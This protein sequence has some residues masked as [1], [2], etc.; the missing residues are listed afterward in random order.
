M[1]KVIFRLL[2]GL[3]VL[4][5]ALGQSVAGPIC[6]ETVALLVPQL[7]YRKPIAA[8]ARVE[9]KRCSE[10]EVLKIAAWSDGATE[11]ALVIDTTDFTIVQTYM[12]GVVFLVETTGGPRNRVYV[13]R[14]EQGKPRL[15]IERV[16]RG[17]TTI[18]D[19]GDRIVITVPNTATGR[20]ETFTF[21]TTQ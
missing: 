2:L 1:S 21:Q 18:M 11:P 4:K 5:C 17:R 20:A 13:I 12:R 7:V 19:I 14:Y 9:V 3:N 10:N 15:A 16:S 8:L 6:G